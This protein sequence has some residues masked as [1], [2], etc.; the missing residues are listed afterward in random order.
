MTITPEQLTA[1]VL[2]LADEHPNAYYVGSGDAGECMYTA[3]RAA[4]A[5]GCLFGQALGN[6]GVEYSVLA[7]ADKRRD[8]I[9]EL[10]LALGI[11]GD[12]RSPILSKWETAQEYQDHGLP[13]LDSVKSLR[14]ES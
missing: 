13:W 12:K 10:A 1:E 7:E 8:S 14:G 9:R 3:G 2:R 4:G 11:T 5:C 6:L